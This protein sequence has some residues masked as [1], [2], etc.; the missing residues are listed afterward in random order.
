MKEGKK[1]R[2]VI[3]QKKTRAREIGQDRA[4]DDKM[5]RKR[6]SRRRG[7]RAEDDKMARKR[8]SR[9]RKKSHGRISRN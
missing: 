3:G 1:N 7:N 6:K 2:A 8:K 5:A 9:G 4:E